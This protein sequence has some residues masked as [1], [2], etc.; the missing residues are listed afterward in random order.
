MGSISAF[1]GMV[2]YMYPEKGGKHHRPHIHVVC[3]DDECVLS[4]PERE[5]LEGSLPPK[6][7]RNVQTFIDM[8]TE[9]LAM[10]WD[11]C[12]QGKNVVWI[13]PIR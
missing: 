5:V 12:M 8:R 3:G 11:L 7:L 2:L 4:V 13:D 6:K 10:N 1:F 9:E